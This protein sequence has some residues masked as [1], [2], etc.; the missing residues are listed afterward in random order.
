MGAAWDAESACAGMTVG[1]LTQHLLGQIEDICDRVAIL[2]RGRIV[3]PRGQV[4]FPLRL[5][6]IVKSAHLAGG[7]PAAPD[8]DGNRAQILAELK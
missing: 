6:Q 4:C 1:G 5:V 7:L 8:L 2:D 3:E